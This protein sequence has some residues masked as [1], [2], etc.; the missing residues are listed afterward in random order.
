MIIKNLK[1]AS[2]FVFGLLLLAGCTV[3]PNYQRPNVAVPAHW[4]ESM[5]G[6]ET[7]SSAGNA[8]MWWKNFNDAKLDLMI[9][10]A[11]QSNLDLKIAAA[12]VRE[13]RAEYQVASAD[14]WPTVGTSDSYQ[15]QRQSKNQPIIGAFNLP[16]NTPFE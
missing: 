4:G 16:P 9:D 3:G 7:N 14:F 2:S 5:A 15:R 8:A 1:S 6:G 12:R 11:V 13:A 10:R